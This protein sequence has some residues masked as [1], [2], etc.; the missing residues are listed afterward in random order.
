M[1]ARQVAIATIT[2]VRSSGEERLLSR[3]LEVLARTGLPVA[4]ADRGT[5]ATFAEGLR[6]L[7]GFR[8]AISNPQ[9]LVAQVQDSVDLASAFGTRFI[10]YLESDKEA[11]L[12]H[13]IGEFLRQAPEEDDVG[14]VLAS[15][16]DAGF[17][18]FPPM[19]RYTEGVINRL[20]EEM[21]GIRG[22]YSYG[23]FVMNRAL[24]QHVSGLEGQLGWGWR[25]STF[26]AASRKG[27]RVV[28]VVGDYACPPDQRK[29][30]D[31]E[32]RHRM[33]QLSQNILGL[34]T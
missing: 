29:E 7:T 13:G 31:G 12:Q 14:V 5:S 15:R 28:H 2:W 6:R 22:D 11:F 19:Q 20:C 3:A 26:L 24:V 32:R 1:D 4:V 8:V 33:R 23:P 25:H 30:D 18:T 10:M 34:T 21:I 16:S 9:G 27:Q 17:Q